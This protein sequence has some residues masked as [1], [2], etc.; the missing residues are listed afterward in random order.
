M[1]NPTLFVHK[2]FISLYT[3]V[4]LYKYSSARPAGWPAGG[5]QGVSHV[6]TSER[7]HRNNSRRARH[8]SSSGTVDTADS[9][10]VSE[11]RSARTTWKTDWLPPS[12]CARQKETLTKVLVVVSPEW[13][14]PQHAPRVIGEI[15]WTAMHPG[16]SAVCANDLHTR[17]RPASMILRIVMH[18]VAAKTRKRLE[19]TLGVTTDVTLAA[20]RSERRGGRPVGTDFRDARLISSRGSG[21]KRRATVPTSP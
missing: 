9:S 6:H 13:T 18:T 3:G 12:G 20:R 2:Y 21:T 17:C 16:W 8:E 5:V 7:R 14:A 11:S 15:I 1:C 19:M 4:V 10:V